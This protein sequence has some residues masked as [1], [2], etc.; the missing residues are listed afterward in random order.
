[1]TRLQRIGSS[2][3]WI[4]VISLYLRGISPTHFASFLHPFALFPQQICFISPTSCFVSPTIYI[5]T[6]FLSSKR[7]TTPEVQDP[8]PLAFGCFPA[9]P[10]WTSRRPCAGQARHQ[11]ARLGRQATLGNWRSWSLQWDCSVSLLYVRFPK[12]QTDTYVSVQFRRKW[13][14]I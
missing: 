6:H 11:A 3:Y 5:L 13:A 9:R 10:V 1:M 4:G 14:S 2:A 12:T 8:D 7:P